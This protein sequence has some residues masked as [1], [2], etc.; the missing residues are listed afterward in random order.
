[1]SR[2]RCPR[3]IAILLRVFLEHLRSLFD[4]T[5]RRSLMGRRL[6]MSIVVLEEMRV[7]RRETLSSQ[8]REILNGGDE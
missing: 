2:L 6:T 7:V 4:T 5:R 8:G 3:L 1:M